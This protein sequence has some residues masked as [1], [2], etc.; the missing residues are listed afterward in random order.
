M[1]LINSEINSKV[2][3][4]KDYLMREKKNFWNFYQPHPKYQKNEKNYIPKKIWK[5]VGI[6]NE[7]TNMIIQ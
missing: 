1:G 2:P 3:I 5:E 4:D 6:F 7:W